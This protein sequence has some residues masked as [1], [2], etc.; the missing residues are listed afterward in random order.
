MDR[1][2]FLQISQFLYKRLRSFRLLLSNQEAADYL[3]GFLGYFFSQKPTAI[4]SRKR[5]LEA[6][7]PEAYF[8]R[9]FLCYLCAL[10]RK[11]VKA[12]EKRTREKH[13]WEAEAVHTGWYNPQEHPTLP[14]ET[15]RLCE[16]YAVE[17]DNLLAHCRTYRKIFFAVFAEEEPAVS[18][19]RMGLVRNTFYQRK[20]RLMQMLRDFALERELSA[21]EVELVLSFYLQTFSL[22][23]K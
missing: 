23:P 6:S 10:H 16:R 19:S 20:R 15:R 3:S 11:A 5:A 13:R 18:A 2:A 17:L 1:D 22:F 7:N 8:A 12:A 9:C 21:Q 4:R 14:E